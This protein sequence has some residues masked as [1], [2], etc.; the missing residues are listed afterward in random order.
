MPQIRARLWAL[1]GAC[2]IVVA[3]G[4]TGAFG[5]VE[6][7][8][9]TSA[10][11]WLSLFGVT[12]K[13]DG[14]IYIVGSKA[15]LLV[16]TD[17]G[18]TWLQ[19]TLTERPGSPLFQDRDF[20]SIRFTA[21]GKTGWICGEEGIILHST[22]GG[23]TWTR[24]ESTAKSN[25][26]KLY[27]VDDKTA[28]AVG[29]NATALRTV[30]GGDH[31]Q[32]VKI[33]KAI[34]LFD[35]TFSDKNTGWAVG[36]FSTILKTTDGGETW[37]VKSGGNMG[38]YTIGPFFTITFTDPQHGIAAGL[39]GDL[40]ITSDGGNTWQPA[41]LPDSSATYILVEDAASKKLWAG[42]I[43]GKIFDQNA[44]GQWQKTEQVT[45]RDITDMAFVGNEGVAVGLN[46]TI[47]LT[48]NAGEQWQAVQ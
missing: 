17:H 36:E 22:D 38:E 4:A 30:D 24:Q 41:K 35:I 27:V 29:A 23:E 43:G 28:Y 18:K 48:S 12:I 10:P 40:S 45:F 47:L 39:S 31:W 20:Y 8:V 6:G 44:S 9:R 5:A 19:R 37:L 33:P 13:A 11:A 34:D 16:S 26:F 1:A 7:T 32:S 42:G 3:I 21:D 14:S 25:L 2:L 15:L 46:G